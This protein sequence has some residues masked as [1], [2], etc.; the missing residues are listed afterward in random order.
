VKL[1]IVIPAFNE[2]A[3][4][5]S[6]LTSLPKKLKGILQTEILVVDDGSTDNTAQLAKK[7]RVN[8][9]RHWI[10]R[11]VGAATKTGLHWAKSK[12]ADIVVT[13]DADGQHDPREIRKIID[14]V[15]QGRAD[16]VIGS[17]L[18]HK[19]SIP[20]DRYLINWFANIA[21]F[22]LF[23]V[24]STDTQSGLRAFSKKAVK[25]IDFKADRMDYSSEIL[26][27]AKKHQLKVVEI[28]T[29]AIYTTYSRGKGQKN[30]N[31][32]PTFA[33]FLVKLFR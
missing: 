10:N 19:Q 5:Y 18:K 28:P 26:L 25:I 33:R 9:A 23:G 13:F 20:V 15:V 4:I 31:A 22:I 24:T 29:K 32:I 8:I 7:A 1:V 21:T 17:R 14:P 11:G 3:V 30:I 12:D 6:V 2:S 27:E 16:V